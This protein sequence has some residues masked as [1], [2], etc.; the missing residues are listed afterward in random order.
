VTAQ[1]D[2]S[3]PSKSFLTAISKVDLSCEAI[4]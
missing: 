4:S 1:I 3:V 2:R